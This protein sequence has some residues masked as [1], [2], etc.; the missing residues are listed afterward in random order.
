MN[1]ISWTHYN[2]QILIAL[3]N[4]DL[5]KW[6]FHL[7][8]ILTNYGV[9]IPVEKIKVAVRWTKQ[10]VWTRKYYVIN[11]EQVSHFSFLTCDITGRT[12]R[13]E[14]NSTKTHAWSK[15]LT[16]TTLAAILCMNMAS[17]LGTKF[18]S[19]KPFVEHYQRHLKIKLS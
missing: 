5:K 13:F 9:A 16:L 18:I 10:V 12:R 7:H 6:I 3:I 19:I 14:Q 17:I 8:K 2:L 11:L 1:A 4:D 15:F